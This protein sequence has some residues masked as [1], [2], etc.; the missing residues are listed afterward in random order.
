MDID[1]VKLGEWFSEKW[2]HGPCPV[3][4]TNRWAPLPRLGVV[5]NINPPGLDGGNIVPV[6]LIHCT[7]CG[8]MLSVNALVA[9]VVKGPDWDAELAQY[10]T[11]EQVEHA[12][13]TSG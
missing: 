9:G 2:Q 4:E 5:P 11:A 8:Y 3:C 13:K 7:N 12:P 10:G 6:L 1:P